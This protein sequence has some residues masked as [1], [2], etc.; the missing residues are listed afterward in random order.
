M[1]IALPYAANLTQILVAVLIV[2]NIILA[3]IALAEVLQKH[4]TI[5]AELSA[6]YM[7]RDEGAYYFWILFMGLGVVASTLLGVA[8]LANPEAQYYGLVASVAALIGL[9]SYEHVWVK[10]G[11]VPPLS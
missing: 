2:S 10:A 5:E 8:Y 1:V 3:I 7:T 9:Y 6:R 11:Q 4:P